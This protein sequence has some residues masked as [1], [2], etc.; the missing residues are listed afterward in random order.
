MPVY[1]CLA[2]NLCLLVLFTFKTWTFL[3][4]HNRNAFYGQI[5]LADLLLFLFVSDTHF[6]QYSIQNLKL[7]YII[8]SP[9]FL[10]VNVTYKY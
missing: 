1:F 3:T 6:A 10:D 5:I 4:F 9:G 8:F 7:V 2:L